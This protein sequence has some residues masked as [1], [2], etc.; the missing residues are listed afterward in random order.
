MVVKEERR[1]GG[2][3]ERRRSGVAL[4]LRSQKK[5][6]WNE[7]GW[8]IMRMIKQDVVFC[9][10]EMEGVWVR[11]KWIKFS[12]VWSW[13]EVSLF[14]VFEILAMPKSRLNGGLNWEIWNMDKGYLFWVW[15][16]ATGFHY[17]CQPLGG[18]LAR[19]VTN[20]K[21]LQ[22][23]NQ[24]QCQHFSENINN[25]IFMQYLNLGR[26][27][28]RRIPS[29]LPAFRQQEQP[30]LSACSCCLQRRNKPLRR[31]L[32]DEPEELVSR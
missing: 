32:E 17:C 11:E 10:M 25:V 30:A 15:T 7:N 5:F 16:S 3:I 14:F 18:Y 24:S 31:K 23:Q 29:L 22:S 21:S 2:M 1:V 12:R 13:F 6:R 27:E 28:I 19:H 4:W 20:F 8:A 26:L 9:V